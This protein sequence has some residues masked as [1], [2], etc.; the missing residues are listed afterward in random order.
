MQN[1]GKHFEEQVKK[2]VPDNVYYYRCR[3][4]AQSFQKSALYSHKNDF[5]CM[6]F[7]SGHLF[8]FELKSTKGKSCSFETDPSENAIIHYHQ[9]DGLKKAANYNGIIP[10][11]LVNWRNDELNTQITYAITISDFEEMINKINKKSFNV[12]DMINYGAVKVDS[13]KLK[14]NYKYDI[15]KLLNDLINREYKEKQ[16]GNREES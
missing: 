11:F 14:V 2:S 16:D 7:Y 15:E 5:D 10:C 3:D 1:P 6:M 8:C 12:V 13:T 4:E 9:I